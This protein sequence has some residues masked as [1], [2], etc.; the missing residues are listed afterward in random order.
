MR[1]HGF[2]LE[3]GCDACSG[4]AHMSQVTLANEI[5]FAL[6][7]DERGRLTFGPKAEGSPYHVNIDLDCPEGS[8]FFGLYHTHP[9]GFVTPSDQDWHVARQL[10]AEFL[11]VEVPDTDEMECYEVVQAQRRRI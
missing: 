8:N 3:C 11:C 2:L 1:H 6:C 10:G 4:K 9:G 7:R 5:G